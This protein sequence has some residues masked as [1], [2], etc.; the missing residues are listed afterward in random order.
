MYCVLKRGYTVVTNTLLTVLKIFA[1]QLLTSVSSMYNDFVEY[2]CWALIR[3][4]S[5]S[6]NLK[7]TKTAP[8]QEV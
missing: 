4:Q 2:M 1:S 8:K 3:I 6:L 5:E 7:L